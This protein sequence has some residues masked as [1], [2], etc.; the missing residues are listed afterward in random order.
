[1]PLSETVIAATREHA[2]GVTPKYDHFVGI[3]WDAILRKLD[4]VLPGYDQ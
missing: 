2:F 1:M 3:S 4:R